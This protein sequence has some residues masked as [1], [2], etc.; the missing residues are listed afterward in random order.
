M[1]LFVFNVVEKTG[2]LM[3]QSSSNR[4]LLGKDIKGPTTIHK[5]EI[6]RL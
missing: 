2:D 5:K 6:K 1:L 3:H 4:G